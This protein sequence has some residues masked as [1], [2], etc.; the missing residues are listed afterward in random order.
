MVQIGVIHAGEWAS[1]LPNRTLDKFRCRLWRKSRRYKGARMNAFWHRAEE[2]LFK[3]NKGGT[4]VLRPLD[5]GPFCV[6][7]N[8]LK[9]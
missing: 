6:Q 1:E 9:R 4:T 3:L 5:E 8:N 2:S 7:L